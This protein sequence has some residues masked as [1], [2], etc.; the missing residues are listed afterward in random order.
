M[1]PFRNHQPPPC[2][3]AV[4]LRSRV[5]LCTAAATGCVQTARPTRSRAALS[6]STCT[7]PRAMSAMSPPVVRYPGGRSAGRRTSL[8]GVQNSPGDALSWVG[9]SAAS[10][11]PN[12]FVTAGWE[13][14]ATRFGAAG[15]T[16]WQTGQRYARCVGPLYSVGTLDTA[17]RMAAALPAP[18]DTELQHRLAIASRLPA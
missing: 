7:I 17:P 9:C 13:P 3:I 14:F 11:L 12:Q 18:L 8:G 1:R 16:G 6:T 2:M 5:R 4:L 15:P 10:R